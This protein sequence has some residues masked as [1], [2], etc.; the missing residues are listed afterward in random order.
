MGLLAP[1]AQPCP[2]RSQAPSVSLLPS[3]PHSSPRSLQ[4]QPRPVRMLLLPQS[5]LLSHNP[6]SFKMSLPVDTASAP[7]PWVVLPPT[8]ISLLQTLDVILSVR[9]SHESLTC[10][11]LSVQTAEGRTA[12]LAQGQAQSR[13]QNNSVNEQKSRRDSEARH[14]F[15]SEHSASQMLGTSK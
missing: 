11:L 14:C 13:S 4:V 5:L 1:D 8:L 9:V 3:L 15:I 10:A 6:V 7:L 2:A 12:P